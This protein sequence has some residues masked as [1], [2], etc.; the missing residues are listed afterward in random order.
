MP[1]L[2]EGR[3]ISKK[4]AGKGDGV[5][6]HQ[7]A[8]AQASKPLTG[9]NELTAFTHPLWLRFRAEGASE[10]AKGLRGAE[11]NAR[12]GT[13]RAVSYLKHVRVARAPRRAAS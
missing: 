3:V 6:S 13:Q 2:V 4:F 5:A 7:A 8:W 1:W 9:P 12:M 10:V 11:A